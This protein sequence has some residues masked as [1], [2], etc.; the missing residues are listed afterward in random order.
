MSALKKRILD[1]SYKHNLSHIGSCLTAVGIIDDIY[2]QITKRSNPSDRFVLSSGHAG[3]AL[4][5]V[6]EKY[7]GVDAQEMLKNQGIHPDRMMD[8]TDLI[9]CSTGS[10]GLGLPIALGMAIADRNAQIHCLISD[11]ECAEGSIWETLN[12]LNDYPQENLSIY[13]NFNGWGAYRQVN[14]SLLDI[15]NVYK[16]PIAVYVYKTPPLSIF[17]GQDAHYHVLSEEEY[18]ASLKEIS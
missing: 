9:H 2:D 6:L 1:L 13:L 12:Y 7:Y 4:Y 10:L 3:L 14:H 16:T 5:V 11:G 17:K 15:L 8:H 18:H